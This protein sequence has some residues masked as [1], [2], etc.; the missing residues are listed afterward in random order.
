LEDG[1][2]ASACK[3]LWKDGTFDSSAGFTEGFGASVVSLHCIPR[4]YPTEAEEKA[5]RALAPRLYQQLF[6]APNPEHPA[7]G[8]YLARSFA[9]ALFSPLGYLSKDLLALVG[10][11]DCGKG[12]ITAA[13]KGAFGGGYVQEFALNNL[14]NKQLS[15]RDSLRFDWLFPTRGARVLIANE[16]DMQGASAKERLSLNGVTIKQLTSGGDMISAALPHGTQVQLK[17][18]AVLFI[19]ANDLPEVKPPIGEHMRHLRFVKSF[20]QQV[21]AT[22]LPAHV[23]PADVTLK[24]KLLTERTHQDAIF[25]MLWDIYKSKLLGKTHVEVPECVVHESVERAAPSDLEIVRSILE[26][27]EEEFTVTGNEWDCIAA[28]QLTAA[29]RERMARSDIS[30]SPANLNFYLAQLGI[31]SPRE[32]RRLV[33]GG[34]AVKVKTGVALAGVKRLR[35]EAF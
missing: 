4:T 33:E 8:D 35:E 19:N 3:L 17:N 1:L 34:K 12:M 20:Q 9:A 31:G 16:V 2:E 13:I 15:G 10:P 21:G 18:R 32:N 26:D 30:M 11:R 23:L 29:I 6:V 5:A 22:A 24:S 7:M 25:F 28:G 27:L 14:L